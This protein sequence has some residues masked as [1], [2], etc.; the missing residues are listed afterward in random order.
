LGEIGL[1]PD[2]ERQI[3]IEVGEDDVLHLRGI[4][5]L[6]HKAELLTAYDLLSLIRAAQRLNP[7]PCARRPRLRQGKNEQSTA[8]MLGGDVSEQIVVLGENRAVLPNL[9]QRPINARNGGFEAETAKFGIGGK[10]GGHGQ[11]R[12]CRSWES[13]QGRGG[14]NCRTGRGS[15]AVVFF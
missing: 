1:P 11:E 12:R 5:A 3:G 10:R 8:G 15:S 14:Q 9:L 2:D 13:A 7:R 6:E 4:T